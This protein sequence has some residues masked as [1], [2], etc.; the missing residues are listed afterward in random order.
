MTVIGFISCDINND[1]IPNVE[2]FDT[3]QPLEYFPAYPGSYWVYSNND[4][5]RVANQYEEYEYNSASYDAEPE[6]ETL[7]LPKLILNGI[8]N[9]TDSFAYVNG[10]SIS[11]R[12]GS[13]Y[14]D[15]A[16]KELLSLEEGTLFTIGGAFQNYQITG[17]TIKVDTTIIIGGITY[18]NTII[19]I[20]YDEGCV[21]GA[22]TSPENCAYKKEYYAKNI[23][24]IKREKKNGLDTTYIADFELVSCFINN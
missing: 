5:L 24:L 6:Y 2:Y 1:T 4:T 12:I 18:E 10:N 17:K 11:K 15:P 3:I 8:F 21:S 20:E 22:L 9:N 16:F 14:R 23:G 13:N 7:I 19:T